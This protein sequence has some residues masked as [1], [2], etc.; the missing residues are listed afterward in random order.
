MEYDLAL[1]KEQIEQEVL[2]LEQTV[3]YLEG[4]T[5]KKII[6]VPGKIINIVL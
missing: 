1:S 6:I 5:P 4:K 2:S 3:K